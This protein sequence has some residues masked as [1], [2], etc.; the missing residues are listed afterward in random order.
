M[1]AKDLFELPASLAVFKDFFKADMA[2][3]EWIAA[4]KPALKSIDFSALEQRQKIPEGVSIEGDVFIDPS[5]ELPPFARIEGPAW[6]GAKTQIRPGAYIRGNV[7]IGAGCVIGNSC[8]YK[9]SLLLDKVQTPHY[10]YVGD[11][12]L[13]NGSHLGAGVICSN[14][15]LD[16]QEVQAYL[17]EGRQSTGMRKLGAILG[18][19]AE[20]GC[21][22]SLQP[23][24]ILD[25][26]AVVM[27]VMAFG[28]YLAP[29]SIA[30]ERPSW[31]T[32]PRQDV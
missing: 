17:P 1:Q 27:P 32:I 21:N 4:I 10:N 5:V 2:P 9:N 23:G 8:E 31:K 7:I 30:Y 18:D 12:L 24:S 20:V 13:G 22:A 16:Q 19:Y 6:I 15:R 28:G 3:W 26:Y 11:S 14:L 29:K 25:R